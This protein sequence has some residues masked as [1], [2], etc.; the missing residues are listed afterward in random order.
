M[1][2][3]ELDARGM[4]G[5]GAGASHSCKSS[6]WIVWNWKSTGKGNP[7]RLFSSVF[8]L[9]LWALMNL[10]SNASGQSSNFV[11]G[12]TLMV[13]NVTSLSSVLAADVNGDGKPDLVCADYTAGTKSTN[14]LT[15]F[16]N[17]ANGSFVF[18]SNV[19]VDP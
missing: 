9:A 3:V 7:T 4:A 15:V 8:L 5:G 18:S 11:Y 17:D 12:T 13:T 19:K 10:F 6:G 16:T 2:I 1:K 14:I